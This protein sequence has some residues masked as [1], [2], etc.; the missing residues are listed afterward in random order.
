MKKLLATAASLTLLSSAASAL[1]Y[2]CAV[3]ANGVT[4]LTRGGFA[5]FGAC[6]SACTSMA[7]KIAMSTG[8]PATGTCTPEGNGGAKKPT[9]FRRR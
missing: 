5:S 7:I 3:T 1:T 2:R 8:K 6:Q 4:L 9:P